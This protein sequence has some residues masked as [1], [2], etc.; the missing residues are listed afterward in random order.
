MLT[1]SLL[2]RHGFRHGFSS[3]EGGVSAAPFDTMNLARNV[4]DAPEAVAENHARLARAIGY[5][6]ACLAEAS[7][8]H[9]V[10]CLDV[11]AHWGD[12]GLDLRGVRDEEADALLA[13][14]AG[15][16]V[17]VRTADCVPVLVGDPKTGA[18][19]AI[20][21]GW[22]GAVGGVV[23]RAIEAL[24]A[25]VGAPA[26]RLLAAI[27]PHIRL[28]SFEV[29]DEVARAV[30]AALP[31]G[32]RSSEVMALEPLVH[33]RPG[34]RPHVSLATLVRAQLRLVGLEEE[35]LDDVGGDTCA[36]ATR[37]HSHRRDGARS[38]RQ[39]SVIVAA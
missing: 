38:G 13:T 11:E 12:G 21:A 6:V 36:E 32:V 7:Q 33:T 17:G 10:R 8:V 30:E 16:A 15:L 23:P 4:G 3:R 19:V 14:R 22:R 34:A 28:A 39:L 9:G 25:R 35:S 31:S 18:V 27:G 29:G 20:H 5:D 26:G 2:A 1:S 37:F 24:C